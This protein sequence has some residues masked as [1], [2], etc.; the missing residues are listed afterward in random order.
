MNDKMIDSFMRQHTFEV[1]DNGFSQKVMAAL[2]EAEWSTH[3][4][5]AWK[6][7]LSTL[8]TVVCVVS[9]LA[10]LLFTDFIDILTVDALVFVHTLYVDGVS[11][12][13]LLCLALFPTVIASLGAR[14]VY[15]K[16]M[17]D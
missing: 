17:S 12:N 11:L 2:P 9:L 13:V 16:V 8:W 7:G 10:F 6:N 14:A 1:E 3:V 4:A 15:L 5:R